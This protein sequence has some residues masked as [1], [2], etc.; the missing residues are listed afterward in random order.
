MDRCDSVELVAGAKGICRENVRVSALFIR[1][2]SLD[3]K[4]KRCNILKH[5]WPKKSAKKCSSSKSSATFHN[6]PALINPSVRKES[7]RKRR[8]WTKLRRNSL[9]S[10]KLSWS[11]PYPSSSASEIKDSPSARTFSTR[12]YAKECSGRS[13]SS[14]WCCGILLWYRMI[15]RIRRLL[16]CWGGLRSRIL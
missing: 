9:K 1:L 13:S 8:K 6:T 4:S 10:V 2:C 5:S 11:P 14:R 3:P 16:C 12:H 15:C 7:Q